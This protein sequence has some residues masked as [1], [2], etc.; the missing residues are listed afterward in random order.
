MKEYEGYD[1]YMIY[2]GPGIVDFHGRRY[3]IKPDTEV[4]TI[5]E[6]SDML[7]S[8]K[9][10]EGYEAY[11]S[12][13]KEHEIYVCIKD[14]WDKEG[15]HMDVTIPVESFGEEK[16]CEDGFLPKLEEG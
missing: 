9:P 3:L 5:M 13:A 12:F 7:D 1:S 14:M 11:N 15:R 2:K 10:G 8:R 4:K 6:L 16:I